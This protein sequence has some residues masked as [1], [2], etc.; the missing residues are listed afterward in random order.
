MKVLGFNGSPRRMKKIFFISLLIYVCIYSP[1]FGKDTI[2]KETTANDDKDFI[3]IFAEPDYTKDQINFSPLYRNLSPFI[4]NDEGNKLVATES[5]DDPALIT[6]AIYNNWHKDMVADIRHIGN[7]KRTGDEFFTF[8]RSE[9]PLYEASGNQKVTYKGYVVDEGFLK[10]RTIISLFS[11]KITKDSKIYKDLKARIEQ[12]RKWEIDNLWIKYEVDNSNLLGIV[13][14]KRYKDY[15]MLSIVLATHDKIICHNHITEYRENG[16]LFRVDD[17]G[18]FDPAN[19]KF[20]FLFKTNNAY[21]LVY[22]WDG[23]EGRNI[24]IVRQYQDRF[25]LGRRMYQPVSY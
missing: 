9:G 21:E 6:K 5:L 12:L 16:D 25:I 18:E 14:Y 11:A 17:M 1:C 20:D 19:I 8:E 7:K 3:K 15:V 4:P 24:Y 22:H 2:V 13:L 23:A 10:G